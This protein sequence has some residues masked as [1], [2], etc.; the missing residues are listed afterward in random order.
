M[1]S[2]GWTAGFRVPLQGACHAAALIP[3][4]WKGQPGQLVFHG[5]SR[6]VRTQDSAQPGRRRG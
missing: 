2:P 4:R 1:L 6:Y 3:I 5:R